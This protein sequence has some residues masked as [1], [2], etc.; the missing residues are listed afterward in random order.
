MRR[1][2]F[3]AASISALAASHPWL[4]PFDRPLGGKGALVTCRPQLSDEPVQHPKS[5]GSATPV[6]MVSLGLGASGPLEQFGNLPPSTFGALLVSFEHPR[7][8]SLQ[9]LRLQPALLDGLGNQRIGLLH[10]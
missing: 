9:P 10:Q 5:N 7:G 2:A 6:S 1:L 8:F 4:R 3:I